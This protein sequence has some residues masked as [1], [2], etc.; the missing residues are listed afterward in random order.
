ML[1]AAGLL[2][3]DVHITIAGA[4]LLSP[5]ERELAGALGGRLTLLNRFIEDEEVAVLL[6]RASVLVL[7]YL[8]A[9]QSS[10]PLIAAAFELPVVASAVG[11]FPTE[12]SALGGV[13]VFPGNPHALANGILTQLNDPKPIINKQATFE[14]LAPEF[15]SMYRTVA[16]CRP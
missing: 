16:K 1:R 8:Q 15:F 9:T 2:P 5:I 11:N 14:E 4:G 12:V 10:L 7:P 3:S 13:V 6:Q